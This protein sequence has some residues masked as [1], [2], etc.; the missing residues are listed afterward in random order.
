MGEIETSEYLQRL[1]RKVKEL[2]A[3][4]EFYHDICSTGLKGRRKL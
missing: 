4:L 2:E 3:K 1:K